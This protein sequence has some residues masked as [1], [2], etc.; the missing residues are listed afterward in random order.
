VHCEFVAVTGAQLEVD[1]AEFE[2][3]TISE[4]AEELLVM[5]DAENPGLDFFPDDITD[6]AIA[7]HEAAEAVSAPE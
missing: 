4:I 3:M 1:P 2:G 5:L 7:I 6:A